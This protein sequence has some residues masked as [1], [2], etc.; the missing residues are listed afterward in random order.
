MKYETAIVYTVL[1]SVD[2]IASRGNVLMKLKCKA[3]I[4]VKKNMYIVLRVNHP[5]F[6]TFAAA[7]FVSY[8]SRRR[9]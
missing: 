5:P 3:L 9:T 6:I 7:L 1:L 2:Y 8:H 4:K